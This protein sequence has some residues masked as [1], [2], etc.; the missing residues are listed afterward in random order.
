MRSGRGWVGAW[1]V[2]VALA[3]CACQRFP[4]EAPVGE[5]APPAATKAQEAGEAKSKAGRPPEGINERFLGDVDV[6]RWAKTF[7]GE[8]REVYRE[9]DRIVAAMALE[10]GDAVA[11]VGAGTGAFLKAF[12]TAVGPDGQV[13]AVDISPKFVEHLKARAAKEGLEQVQVHLSRTDDV[14]LPEASVDVVFVCDTYHH[15]EAPEPVLASIRKALKP[16]GRLVV[17]DFER[18]PGK[19][20]KWLLEHVRAGR[21]VFAAE[22]EAAGFTPRPDPAPRFLVDNYM[23]IFERPADDSVER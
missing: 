16:G 10:P 11:D 17:V 18:I 22:I 3:G 12:A 5:A 4:A 6:D 15:F 1:L 2:V 8:S 23:L 9:R 13:H 7:E 19:T 20:E 14:G 21:E